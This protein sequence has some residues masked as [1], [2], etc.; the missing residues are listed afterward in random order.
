[1]ILPCGPPQI[2]FPGVHSSRL[3]LYPSISHMALVCLPIFEFI[4]RS[5]RQSR[6]VLTSRWSGRRASWSVEVFMRSF[7]LGLS[8]RHSAWRSPAT[9]LAQR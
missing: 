1:M 6:I 7:R 9:V 4:I 2:S 3:S 5:V 8:R